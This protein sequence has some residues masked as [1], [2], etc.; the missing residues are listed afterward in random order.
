MRPLGKFSPILFRCIVLI[1]T[2]GSA[3]NLKV[4]PQ[5]TQGYV[6][7]YQGDDGL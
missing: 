6:Y 3:P 5:Q 4:K 2:Q 1:C 7:L